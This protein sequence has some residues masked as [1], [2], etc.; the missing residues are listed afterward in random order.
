M[1]PSACDL[2][3]VDNNHKAQEY[4]K[5]HRS[6]PYF[7]MGFWSIV[8]GISVIVDYSISFDFFYNLAM[9]DLGE[10]PRDLLKMV[11]AKAFLGLSVIILLKASFVM[12]PRI[13][14]KLVF[15]GLFF[16]AVIVSIN[17]GKAQVYS[18]L[19]KYCQSNYSVENGKADDFKKWIGAA[20]DQAGADKVEKNKSAEYLEQNLGMIEFVKAAK[21]YKMAFPLFAFLGLVAVLRLTIMSKVVGTLSRARHVASRYQLLMRSEQLY[22]GFK[23]D[24]QCLKKNRKFLYRA[25]QEE[26]RAAYICGLRLLQKRLHELI[27]YGEKNDV[28]SVYSFWQI[29][30]IKGLIGMNIED[31]KKIIGKAEESLRNIK[32]VDSDETQEEHSLGEAIDEI[33]LDD[34]GIGNIQNV[35]TFERVLEEV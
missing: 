15:I 26:V 24:L 35:E 17:L 1:N 34:F 20:D 9:N 13:I 2:V 31:T 18:M 7:V 19:Y 3:I 22:H 32:L 30:R 16:L 27:I 25:A 5:N 14:Q 8:F 33:N 12:L 11:Y 23:N 28:F 10:V 6:F 29:N 21:W 4:I